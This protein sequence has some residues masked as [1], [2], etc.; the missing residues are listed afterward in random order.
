VIVPIHDPTDPRVADFI[1]LR[2]H[3]RDPERGYFVAEG[4][5]VI[6]HLLR[7]TYRVRSLLV[8]ERGL[9]AL[10]GDVGALDVPVY[11]ADQVVLDRICG[12]NFHR[13]ALASAGRQP[14]PAID[15]L[16]ATATLVLVIEGVND[17]ENM[18]ALFRNAAAFGVD[19]VLLDP[20]SCDPLYRRS[21]RVSV[22]QV[23][24]TRFTRAPEWPGAIG[25][26][27]RGGF[28]VLALTPDGGAV[29]VRTIERA[30]RQA[31]LVGA[32]GT[33]LSPHALAA[34]DRRARMVMAPGVDSLNVATAA[35]VA[36]H[37]LTR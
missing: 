1:G 36:L 20:T 37:E 5:L 32:E 11:V 10:D 18:G 35:A 9:R 6:N 15:D 17:H 14:L 30:P 31:V 8:T 21:I 27:Q 29:D 16:V 13:G 19:A 3:W 25:A 34:A 22:G 23:L 26:V 7:S 2:D 4:P 28:D 24:R 33:G 12:F